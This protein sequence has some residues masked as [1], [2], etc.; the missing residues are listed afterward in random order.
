MLPPPVGGR[1]T[2]WRCFAQKFAEKSIYN[3]QFNCLDGFCKK[4]ITNKGKPLNNNYFGRWFSE[5]GH[6]QD[7]K[8]Q[9]QRMGVLL[10]GQTGPLYG[11]GEFLRSTPLF[12]VSILNS[13]FFIRTLNGKQAHKWCA[14]LETPWMC[15][16]RVV[17]HMPLGLTGSHP[18]LKFH[19][20]FLQLPCGREGNK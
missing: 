12:L 19:L 10:S 14:P 16:A 13:S 20:Q 1:K 11:G 5:M 7:D 4:K 8:A 18:L 15:V 6:A 3:D 9:A 2:R 17:M